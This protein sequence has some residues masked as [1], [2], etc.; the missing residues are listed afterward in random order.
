MI[1][2]AL[3][4]LICA[5]CPSLPTA[6]QLGEP[7][8]LALVAE[9][10][11]APAG[12]SASLSALVAGPD[13]AIAPDRTSWSA[14]A[15]GQIT[16]SGDQVVVSADAPAGATMEIEVEVAVGETIL[17]GFRSFRVGADCANPHVADVV[18]DDASA[19]VLTAR[20]NVDL[21][22]RV[23]RGSASSVAWFTTAGKIDLYRQAPTKLVV[24]DRDGDHV[25]FVVVRDGAG[26][27]GY[28]ERTVTV[29]NG[30]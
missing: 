28:L 12:G 19:T 15:D 30:P 23:D 21:D 29:V 16:V 7:Q 26:G 27:V 8:I 25:L 18:V 20:A 6:A 11:C 14:A 17:R 3:C 24:G 9:P 10:P 4:L 5:G 2:A 1:R 22:V 13:G